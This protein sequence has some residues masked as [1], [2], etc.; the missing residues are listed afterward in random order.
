MQIGDIDVAVIRRSAG[1]HLLIHT[2]LQNYETVPVSAATLRDCVSQ[3]EKL[4]KRVPQYLKELEEKVNSAGPALMTTEPP[5]PR[6]GPKV[7]S[8]FEL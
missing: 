7:D 6:V 1:L 2:R 8:S 3:L 5:P 4:A